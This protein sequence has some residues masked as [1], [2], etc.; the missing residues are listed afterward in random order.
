MADPEIFIDRV[1]DQQR[2][3]HA[4]P[5]GIPNPMFVGDTVEYKSS[6]GDLV[7]IKFDEPDKSSP[8]SLLRSPF[9]DP[10]GNEK[11]VVSS[12]DGK[13]TVSNR[14]IFVSHCFL[15]AP[16]QPEIGWGP[17]SP[18]SGGNHEVK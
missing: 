15:K 14:G 12:T 5:R 7:T 11:T 6:A 16:G 3:E 4:V 10:T 8:A 17:N 18:Q 9:N 13:I 1:V 2:N